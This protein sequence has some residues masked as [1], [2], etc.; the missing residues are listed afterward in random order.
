M[1][2]RVLEAVS[3]LSAGHMLSLD[4]ATGGPNSPPLTS[5]D[6]R[7][8]VVAV[9]FC[10]CTCIDWILTLPFVR[11]GDIRYRDR[12][13]MTLGIQAPQFSFENDVANVRRA[14]DG[15]RMRWPSA[16]D[17]D[18]AIWDASAKPY[19]PSM[20]PVDKRPH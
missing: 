16:L 13:R 19:W 17:S 9:Q 15:M 5:A 18:C 8:K 2:Q 7:E 12:V 10:T 3:R 20:Y 1:A 11:A 4:G 14:L 6:L